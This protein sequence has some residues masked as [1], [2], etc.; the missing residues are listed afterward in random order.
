MFGRDV[1]VA[2]IGELTLRIVDDGEFAVHYFANDIDEYMTLFI[3]KA[4]R[5]AKYCS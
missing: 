5:D 4:R 1:D 3:S 2:E